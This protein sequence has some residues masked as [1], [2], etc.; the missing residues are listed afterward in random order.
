MNR[1]AANFPDDYEDRLGA[2][3]DAG[4]MLR[5]ERREN[6]EH[7][8]TLR[9]ADESKPCQWCCNRLQGAGIDYKCLVCGKGPR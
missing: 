7:S 5:K 9:R 4:D 3:V 1:F 6:P 8:R 2:M